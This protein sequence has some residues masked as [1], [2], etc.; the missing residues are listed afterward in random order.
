M[1][2]C[3][4][5]FNFPIKLL[6]TGFVAKGNTD[7]SLV[8]TCYITFS[9]AKSISENALRCALELTSFS[10][11]RIAISATTVPAGCGTA[12]KMSTLT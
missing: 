9:F 6:K 11:G 3:I 8:L 10:S 5:K 4:N 2:N 1:S 7:K 12:L